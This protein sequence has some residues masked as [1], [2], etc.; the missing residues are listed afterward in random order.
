MP[1]DFFGFAVSLA[2]R[3]L[4]VGAPQCYTMGIGTGA[5]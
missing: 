4:A 5:A 1:N 3:V 2:G